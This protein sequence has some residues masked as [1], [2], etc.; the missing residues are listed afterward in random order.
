M[1]KAEMAVLGAGIVGLSCAIHLQRAGLAVT[2]IDRGEP[3]CETSFGNAGVLSRGSIMPFSTPAV[4][5]NLHRYALNLSAGV[6]LDPAFLPQFTPWFLRFLRECTTSRAAAISEGLNELLRRAVDEHVSLSI[7]AKYAHL[8]RRDGWVRVFRSEGGFRGFR[9]EHEQLRKLG[10]RTEILDSAG[11]AELEPNLHPRFFRGAWYPDTAAV[12][13]PGAVCQA[14]AALFEAEGGT[15]R[16]GTVTGLRPNRDGWQVELE[17]DALNASKV[18][19]AMGAW[20]VDVLKAL[21]VELPLLWERGYHLHFRVAEGDELIRPVNDIEGGFVIAPME[22]GH[23]ITSG[24][25]FA[26]RDGPPSPVQFEPVLRAAREAVTLGECLDATPWLGR[27]PS[28]PDS[29]P[30]ISVAPGQQNLWLA[31]GHGHVGFTAGPVTGRLITDLVT[32]CKPIID[33][34]PFSAER[35]R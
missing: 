2:L 26:R 14:L 25:E 29:L 11:L 12:T 3:G 19:V 21:G 24:I 8:V 16:R 32:G 22:R 17:A 23:R 28:M 4:W 30:V 6:R 9:F 18:A 20:S 33:P 35:F 15:M 27:R 10:V 1:A 5:R 7:D 34:K 13:D 31:F